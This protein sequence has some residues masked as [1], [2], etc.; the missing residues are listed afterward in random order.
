MVNVRERTNIGEYYN[1]IEICYYFIYSQYMDLL[2]YVGAY[3]ANLGIFD[4]RKVVIVVF[5]LTLFT[6]AIITM[7]LLMIAS[8]KYIIS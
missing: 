3:D 1:I 2:T 6:L 8:I 7:L 5:T 4:R